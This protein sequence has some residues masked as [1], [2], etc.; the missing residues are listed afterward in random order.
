MISFSDSGVM[1]CSIWYYL[2]NF[3]NMKNTHGGVLTLL[4]VALL[5]GCFSCFLNCANDTK[6]RNASH[7]IKGRSS[8]LVLPGNQ[9]GPSH[10]TRVIFTIRLQSYC[11]CLL[12][13]LQWEHKIN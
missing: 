11:L 10:Q 3:K 4:K 8:H 6:L 12:G 1:F 13:F 2:Y 9:D 5:H 7:I